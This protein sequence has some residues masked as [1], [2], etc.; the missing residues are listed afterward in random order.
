MKKIIFIF[1]FS[2]IVLFSNAQNWEPVGLGI[3]VDSAEEIQEP[4]KTF[5]V[6]DGKLYLGGHFIDKHRKYL[7]NI[8]SWDGKKIDTVG[9]G[10]DGSVWSLTQAGKYLCI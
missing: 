8:A 6:Y 7:K 9:T 2:L 4:I 3:S 10:I 1:C 5:C